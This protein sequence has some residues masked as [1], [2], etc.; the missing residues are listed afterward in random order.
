MQIKDL[1]PDLIM[2]N[3]RF[4]TLDSE[5]TVAWAVAIKDGR[6]VAVGEDAAIV[7][8]W[9]GPAPVSWI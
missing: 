8:I 4:Y 5:S 6:L 7:G 9:P 3:G 1:S 2:T